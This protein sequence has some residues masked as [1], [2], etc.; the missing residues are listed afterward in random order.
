[1]SEIDLNLLEEDCIKMCQ[2]LIRIP[3]V[4]F[5]EGRGDEKAVADYVAAKLA[6]VGIASELIVTGENRVNVVAKIEGSNQSRPGLVLHGHLDV[7]PVNAADWSV[8]PFGG[9]IKDGYIWGRGAVDM[10]DMDAMIL[11]VARAWKRSG[12]IPDRNILIVFFADEEAGSEYGSRWLVKNRPEIFAGYSEAISEVGGFSVTLD[13]GDRLYFVEG[14]QKGINWLKLTAKG[15]AG[16]GS[17]I[18]NENAITK[19][20]KA[21]ARIGSH[22]WPQIET[23]TGAKFFRKIAELTGNAYDASNVRPLL[24]HIG[25]AARMMGATIQNTSNPTMLEAGYKANVI[26]QVASAVVD[27]RFL[28]GYEEDL[29]KTIA[30]IAGPDI[31]IEVLVRD[32]ALEVEFFG[33]LVDAMCAAI[34]EF[35]PEGIPVPYLMSGGTD[36]KALSDL[37]IVGYGFSPVK[38]PP[39]LDF[40]ALFHGVDERIPVDGLK[41]GVKVLNSFLQRC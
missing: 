3:S 23:K 2:E 25:G 41:F 31:E 33:P 19:L 28:P 37:G 34:A 27:G 10:K 9:I 15:A 36:N 12:F 13:T 7:V 8:D 6:E 4:N 17:F 22:E 40:F 1:M 38:L 29:L 18:N 26:P 32:K 20:S 5:G 21:I 16:H 30:E 11:A 14:A 35:D 24:K 39:E